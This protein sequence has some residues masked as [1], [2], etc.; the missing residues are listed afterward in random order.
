MDEPGI[1][2]RIKNRRRIFVEEGGVRTEAWKE[3]KRKVDKLILERNRGYMNTQR[4]HLLADDAG[5]NFFHHIK[6]FASFEKHSQFD[7]RTLMLGL[8][9]C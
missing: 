4:S 8:S 7:V 1:L 2:K 6:N 5:R 3:E 9:D